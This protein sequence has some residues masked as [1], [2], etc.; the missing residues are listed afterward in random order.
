MTG[1]IKTLLI[2]GRDGDKNRQSI[3]N[4]SANFRGKGSCAYEWVE[5]EVANK[6]EDLQANSD[7]KSQPELP[8]S[9]HI[10]QPRQR[11]ERIPPLSADTRPRS[12]FMCKLLKEM[13]AHDQV[14]SVHK[15][16]QKYRPGHEQ[17]D[18]YRKQGAN[19]E[20]D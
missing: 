5:L 10:T 13:M 3:M 2:R 4:L 9:P 1:R 6:E 16:K 20:H 17:D 15:D 12:V 11:F 7:N 19:R 14:F 8:Y 18:I